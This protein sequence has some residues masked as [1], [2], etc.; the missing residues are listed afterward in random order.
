MLAAGLLLAGCALNGDFGRVRPE[1]LTD[2]MHNWIGHDAATSIGSPASLY[3]LTDDERTLR[4]FAFPLIDPPYNRN[5]WDSVLREYGDKHRPE[6]EGAPIDRTAYWRKSILAGRRSEASAYAQIVT[7]ARNDV[8]RMEPFFA[9][10]GRVIEMDA[11]RTKS[12]DY[13]S[14][15]SPAEVANA[16]ARNNEN[17]AIVGWVCR[18]LD[19]RAAA[20]RFALERLVIEVPSNAA[21]EAERS[22]TLMR[23]RIG[24]YCQTARGGPAGPRGGIV[25]K[26]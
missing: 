9:L 14:A 23:M 22:I 13:V 3:P 10:A 1:L 5:R 4:D 21:A 18:A 19:A 2:D 20:Y 25:S 17:W 26:G 24:Q 11:R 15:L 7:D 12:L 6:I 16:M 8:D